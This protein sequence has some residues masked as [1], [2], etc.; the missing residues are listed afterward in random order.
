MTVSVSVRMLVVVVVSYRTPT[1]VRRSVKRNSAPVVLRPAPAAMLQRGVRRYSASSAAFQPP[2]PCSWVRR[3]AATESA[4]GACSPRKLHSGAPASSTDQRVCGSRIVPESA[5]DGGALAAATATT[6]PSESSSES[7]RWVSASSAA[8]SSSRASRRAARVATVVSAGPG[9]FSTTATARVR[10][11][12]Y[13]GHRELRIESS[14][15]LMV[16]TMP[17]IVT[18]PTEPPGAFTG[19]ATDGSA[20]GGDTGDAV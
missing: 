2:R 14:P 3:R 13:A 4:P 18:E 8:R 1:T 9:R 5:G 10:C 17:P 19:P 7:V 16:G 6:P 11:A 15:K 12:I 20:V